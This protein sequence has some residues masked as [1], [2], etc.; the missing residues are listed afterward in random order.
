MDG[1]RLFGALQQAVEGVVNLA[2]DAR[3]GPCSSTN[4]MTQVYVS[5]ER[6]KPSPPKS[7][8]GTTPDP[9]PKGAVN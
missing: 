3:S 6:T 7:V 8:T 4:A 9:A 2:L 5:R 1:R